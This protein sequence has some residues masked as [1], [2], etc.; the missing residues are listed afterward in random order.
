MLSPISHSFLSEPNPS[1]LLVISSSSAL[2]V[3]IAGCFT[4]VTICDASHR[5]RPDLIYGTES[6][7]SGGIRGVG[8]MVTKVFKRKE[9]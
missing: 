6:V 9:D 3:L 7:F 8:R 1:L 4:L 2:C 5:V